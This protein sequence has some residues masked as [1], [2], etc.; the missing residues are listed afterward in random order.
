MKNLFARHP[1]AIT[2]ATREKASVSLAEL[3]ALRMEAA[4]LQ[5]PSATRKLQRQSG[6]YRSAFRGRGMEF[7]EVRQYQAGDDVRSIDWR[8]TARRQKPHTKLFH[9]ERERPV[10]VLCDQSCTLFFGGAGHFKSVKSAQAAALLAWAALLQGDRCG[11]IVFS[12]HGHVEVKPARQRKS[13]MQYLN[14]LA[15]SNHQLEAL[16]MAQNPTTAGNTPKRFD[17]NDALQEV[18]RIAKPGSLVYL[19]SDFYDFSDD[20]RRALFLL[21]RHCDIAGVWIYDPLERDLPPAGLYA[22]ASEHQIQWLDAGDHAARQ[23]FQRY[24]QQQRESI[25]QTFTRLQAP[26]AEISTRE[27]LATSIEQL[28]Q[29]VRR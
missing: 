19:I 15:Q 22:C 12:D 20:T 16:A 28:G 24:A 23:K 13:V 1:S 6:Q 4:T 17:L 29:I 11:G 21:S 26:L 2:P 3:L 9:E 7:A 25:Q 18:R 27:T 5:L 14:A 8:V 10:V